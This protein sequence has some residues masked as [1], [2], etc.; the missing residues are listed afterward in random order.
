MAVGAI[1]TMINLD[2]LS[3]NC[4]TPFR[5]EAVYAHAYKPYLSSDIADEINQQAKRKCA[6]THVPR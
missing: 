6:N 1:S 3:V 5:E 2:A 4:L